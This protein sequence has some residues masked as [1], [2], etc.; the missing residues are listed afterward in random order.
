MN[1]LVI[2]GLSILLVVGAV[3]GIIAGVNYSGNSNKGDNV[4]STTSKSIAAMCTPTDYKQACVNSLSSFAN[5]GSAT[6][7]DLIQSALQATIEEVKAALQKSGTIGKDTNNSTQKMAVEDCKDLLQFAVDELQASFSMVG[8]SDLH[9]INDKEAELKNWLSTM[10]SYQQTCLDGVTE[11]DL[12]NAMSNGLLNATQL[13][14]NALAIVSAISEI[15]TS[16]KIPLNMTA[17]SRQ[18]LDASEDNDNQYPV[19]LSASDRKLL[20]SNSNGQVT[21]NAIVAKD[22]SGQYKT[23]SE[24]LAA[25]LKNNKGRY[26]IYV[27]AG[28]YDEYITVKK[29]QVNVLMYGDGPRKTMITGKKSNLAG[30]PTFQ[31]ASFAA[32]GTGFIAKSMGFQNTA[33]PEG[34]QADTLYV[35]THRQFYHNCVISGTVDFIFGDSATL[36]QNCK[37]IVRKPM[38]HQSNTITAHGRSDKREN[39]GLVIQN[40]RIVPEEK[41]YPSRL[42]IA[43][44]LARPWK[45][46]AC[47]VIMESTLGDFIQPAGWL[48]WSGNFALDT[49]HYAE[50]ANQ[51][52][53][54]KTDNR[55]KWKGHKVIT[56]RNEALQFTAGPFIQGNLWL[57]A[58]G[59]PYFP[60]FKN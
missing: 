6:P 54:A 31:T 38:D 44:Y 24:A 22:G 30:L 45:E 26:V 25:Y 58:T 5:N 11:P 34:H 20:A 59:A 16:F 55:V 46:Y 23:I 4:L 29:D 50:Y 3:I 57:S 42:Q 10:I 14:S 48:E 33:G 43:S 27:K 51:G 39:T 17:S 12:K 36:I 41:L 32:V 7:K 9:T 21:P 40:C 15:M 49:L 18:L 35:Q 1:K 28:I 8:D 19:W 47:T 52:P 56:N 37:I 53:G 60:G 13:T 2:G